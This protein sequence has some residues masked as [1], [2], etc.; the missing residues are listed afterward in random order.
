MSIPTL[1]CFSCV[2]SGLYYHPCLYFKT[3]WLTQPLLSWPVTYT[4]TG[5]QTI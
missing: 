5:L 1:S 3:I 2:I 4:I